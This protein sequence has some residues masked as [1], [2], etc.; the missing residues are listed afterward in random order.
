MVTGE[1][2]RRAAAMMIGEVDRRKTAEAVKCFCLKL[3]GCCGEPS[4]IERERTRLLNRIA[5][6]AKMRR[7]PV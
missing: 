3:R 2:G 4:S 1:R 7:E 6:A 5:E